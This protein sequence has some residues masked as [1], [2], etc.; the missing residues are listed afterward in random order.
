MFGHLQDSAVDQ[1]SDLNG[2]VVAAS[3]DLV[4]VFNFSLELTW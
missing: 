1:Q 4:D 2:S 3:L